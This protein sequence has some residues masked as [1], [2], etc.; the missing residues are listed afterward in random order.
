MVVEGV[1]VLVSPVKLLIIFWLFYKNRGCSVRIR[2]WG[3]VFGIF[4]S[5]ALVVE[6]LRYV[7]ICCNWLGND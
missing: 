7:V 3:K 6:V 4:N 2:K 5:L 1:V